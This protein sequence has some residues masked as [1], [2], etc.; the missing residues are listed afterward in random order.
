MSCVS[1]NRLNDVK[2]ERFVKSEENSDD[3]HIKIEVHEV[4]EWC[5]KDEKYNKNTWQVMY[6]LTNRQYRL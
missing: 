6:V 5:I 2:L 1:Y 3:I 4:P